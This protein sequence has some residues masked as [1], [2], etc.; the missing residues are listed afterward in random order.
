MYFTEWG[1][2]VLHL[3]EE[4]GGIDLENEIATETGGEDDREK[5][6]EGIFE[7]VFLLIYYI[8]LTIINMEPF[9]SIDL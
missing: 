9:L 7:S 5:E 4:D 6:D 3:Q 2:V 8:P 1:E